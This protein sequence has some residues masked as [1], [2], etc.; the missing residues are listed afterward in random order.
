MPAHRADRFC[1]ALTS[2]SRSG[3]IRETSLLLIPAPTPRAAT[4]SR[5]CGWRRLRP[6]PASPPR[7]TPRRCAGAEPAATGRTIPTAAW[8]SSL[9]GRRRWSPP[10]SRGCRCTGWCE[11]A[12]HGASVR[13]SRAGWS[14]PSCESSPVSSLAGSHRASRGGP[15]TSVPDTITEARGP[16]YTT[17]G[18]S[19]ASWIRHPGRRRTRR[20]RPPRRRPPAIHVHPPASWA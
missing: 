20:R 16:S 14:G 3:Q 18:H 5:P 11:S 8:E 13:S 4:R 15:S 1:E 19:P 2:A 10:A 6:S 12:L 17:P 9:S 7:A